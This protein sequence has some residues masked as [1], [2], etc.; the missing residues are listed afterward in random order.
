MFSSAGRSVLQTMLGAFIFGD[1][2]TTGRGLSI[3][4]I[5]VGSTYYVFVMNTTPRSPKPKSTAEE[6]EAM[7]KDIEMGEKTPTK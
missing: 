5:T 6:E 1:I 4:L 2:I 7:L 3:A